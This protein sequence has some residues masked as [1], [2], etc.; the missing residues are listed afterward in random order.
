MI[1]ST[2]DYPPPLHPTRVRKSDSEKQTYFLKL[3]DS[4]QHS[5]VKREIKLLLEAEKQGL[6]EQIHI[7]KLEAFVSIDQSKTKILGFLLSDIPSPTPLTTL[8][9]SD[10]DECKR[11]RWADE[12]RRTTDL[13][14]Q[15]AIIW[16]DAKADN[17]LVDT[18]DELWI[19]DFGGSYTEGWVDP[20]LNETREGDEMGVRKIV[21]ALRD[22]DE[23]AEEVE[24]CREKCSEESEDKRHQRQPRPEHESRR[25]AE[26]TLK[27]VGEGN[28]E[29]TNRRKRKVSEEVRESD[30]KS[31]ERPKRPKQSQ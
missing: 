21:D 18:D 11:Q 14:H 2:S 30:S 10:V 16:G 28:E 20:D 3:V 1:L 24:E 7:P 15:H 6:C 26:Q 29:S 12:V 8:L 31:F 17:F 25:N 22:P 4:S 5:P 19:I 23:D 9:N 13:L 27:D